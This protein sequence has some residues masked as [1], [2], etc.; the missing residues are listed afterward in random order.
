MKTFAGVSALLLLGV[1]LMMVPAAALAQCDAGA[2]GATGSAHDVATDHCYYAFA[3]T[4]SWATAESACEAIGGYLAVIDS[5]AENTVA[6]SATGVSLGTWIGF[7]DQNVEAGTNAF[8]FEKVTGGYLIHNGFGPGEPNNLGNEDCVEFVAGTSHWNDLP[9]SNLRTYLCEVPSV[10]G[11]GIV[12]GAEGCD[13]GNTTPGDGCDASC[14]IEPCWAC[15]GEPSVCELEIETHTVHDH[16]TNVVGLHTAIAIG[17]DGFPLISYHD[18]S[19][20][21][22]MVVHCTDTA[23]A[24]ADTPVLL[25]SGSGG[26]VGEETDI[27]FDAS[28]RALISY[29][30]ATNQDLKVAYC[31]DSACTSATHLTLDGG[32]DLTGRFSLLAFGSDGFAL[33]SYYLG[34]PDENLRLI[35]CQNAD[36]SASAAP[37]ILDGANGAGIF[38]SIAI[39]PNDGLARIAYRAGNAI[40]DI[41]FLRCTDTACSTWASPVT[42]DPSNSQYVSMTIGGDQLPLVIGYDLDALH[43]E[44]IHCANSACSSSTNFA[45]DSAG[46]VGKYNSITTGANGLGVMSYYDDGLDNLKLAW[47]LN[48][49]CSQKIVRAVD[50]PGDVGRYTSIAVDGDGHPVVSYHDVTNGSLKVAHCGSRCGD[51]N[52][53]PDE[54]CDDGDLANGDG[55]SASCTVETCWDC[56]GDPSVCTPETSGNSCPGDGVF[57]N[58]TESCNGAGACV[59]GGDPCSSG[60]ECNTVCNEGTDDCFDPDGIACTGDGNPCTEDECDGAGACGHEA[61]NPGAIC[62]PAIDVCDA[63]ELCDGANTGCPADGFVGS[64]TPCGD[65]SDTVC[66]DP[67]TCDGAGGCQANQ[68]SPSTT[69]RA[70]A[71]QCDVAEQCDGNGNCP[72]D[73]FEPNTTAC[74][75]NS[76]CTQIDTCNGSGTCVGSNPLSCD[77]NNVCT[78]NNCDAVNGCQNPPALAGGCKSAAKAILIL[79]QSGGTLDKQLFKWV[80]GDILTLADLADPTTSTKYGVCM[81]TGSGN[82]QLE[83]ISVPAGATNWKAVGTVGYKYKELTGTNS[84]ITKM[85]FRGND[86]AGRSKALVKGTGDN[87][88]DPVLGNM[89]LPVTVQVVNPDTGACVEAVF[90]TNDV[91][92]NTSTLFKA[93]AQ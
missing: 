62:R 34:L 4:V 92:K 1:H 50:E 3:A 43:L 21:D 57:C 59:G 76:V 40:D 78:A 66:T 70:D 5:A 27:A 22:L 39:D 90:D 41:R 69:C 65:P 14:R 19:N 68:A 10:C 52:K 91:K 44:A 58:G 56:S 84:G 30:D 37:V 32:S 74:D 42:A 73:A 36:C 82:A 71:G 6:R 64:G 46:D 16:P 80:N 61:G 79:K 20:G 25:D 26:D 11:N 31:V 67:D 13:D 93:K 28:G 18:A 2:V 23:C 89:Q 38:T 86:T 81:Y 7:H 29:Y 77:D 33:I 47:C 17:V 72:P 83:F 55:C 53:T 60:S 12:D 87:L 15:G 54:E 88:P 48:A 35:H 8:A 51:G 45:V 75:D 63:T 49:D 9:C 24:T 85:L